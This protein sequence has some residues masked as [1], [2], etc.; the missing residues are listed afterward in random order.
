MCCLSTDQPH[1]LIG[2]R[3]VLTFNVARSSKSF[4]ANC[5]HRLN[6]ELFR[7]VLKHAKKDTPL[8]NVPERHTATLKGEGWIILNRITCGHR[9]FP[10]QTV[11][12]IHKMSYMPYKPF[13]TRCLCISYL[14]C[15]LFSQ[16]TMS[17]IYQTVSDWSTTTGTTTPWCC[18]K[19]GLTVSNA[20][21]SLGK[22]FD[23]LQ[24]Q[25]L[26]QTPCEVRNRRDEVN[27][28]EERSICSWSSAGTEHLVICRASWS[29]ARTVAT[30]R[31]LESYLLLLFIHTHTPVVL[32]DKSFNFLVRNETALAFQYL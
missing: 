24:D 18:V 4:Q 8:C 28:S 6:K 5:L 30:T 21:L 17:Q 20:R 25:Y 14:N 23:A 13:V 22:F 9:L 7:I 2:H 10:N 19:Y 3:V 11:P 26:Q 12:T 32:I 27:H 15:L 1:C 31:C 29:S 16:S